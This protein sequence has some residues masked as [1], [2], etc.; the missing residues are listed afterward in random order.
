[1]ALPSWTSQ[2][3]LRKAYII[4]SPGTLLDGA[5]LT[6]IGWVEGAGINDAKIA[7]TLK[8]SFGSVNTGGIVPA[9][10]NPSMALGVRAY[11]KYLGK[12]AVPGT[13]VGAEPPPASHWALGNDLQFQWSVA[14]VGLAPPPVVVTD[15]TT[16]IPVSERVVTVSTEEAAAQVRAAGATPII[17]PPTEPLVIAP[18]LPSEAVPYQ[19]AQI[20]GPLPQAPSSKTGSGPP[21]ISGTVGGTLDQPQLMVGAGVAGGAVTDSQD[22]A[23][24]IGS[25]PW[26]VWAL[27]AAGAYLAWKGR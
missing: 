9:P 27:V 26:W 16:E 6:A 23:A 22:V 25:V 2:V 7:V 15:Q 17:V 21:T 13:V 18:P 14:T 11:V 1:M 10:P 20:S 24:G 8:G 3:D 12:N 5:S 4:A 19:T